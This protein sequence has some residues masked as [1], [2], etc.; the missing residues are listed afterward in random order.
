VR[1]LDDGYR[2]SNK[3][4]GYELR[5]L[6]RRMVRLGVPLDHPVWR[7]ERDRQQRVRERYEV[8]RQ[9]H[10]DRSPSWWWD[11]H[12]VDLSDVDPPAGDD[13]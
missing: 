5:R 3:R 7:E 1:L 13:G 8:L 10:G 12:G 4:Q 11:T 9:R 2:P 6:L